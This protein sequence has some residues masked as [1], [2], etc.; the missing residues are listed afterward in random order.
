MDRALSRLALE[1]GGPRDLTAIR[2]GLE[3]ALLI[4]AA[5][6]ADAP[7][8]MQQ[9]ITD[10]GGHDELLD[11]LD[12]A[13][14]AEPPLLTRDGGFIAP[15]YHDELDEARTLRDEGRGV[16]ASMQAEYAEITG[17]SSLKVKHNNVLGYFI[18]C[19]ATHADKML[20]APLNETFIHRQT[21]ANAVR[22]TTVDLSEL[23]TRIL[24]A[25]GRALEIEK[26]LFETLRTAVLDNADRIAQSARALSEIDLTCAF[27]DLARDLNWCAPHIDDSRAFDIVGGRHPVVERALQK[28]GG[29]PF[30]ANDCN[31]SAQDDAAIWLLTGPNMAGKSTFLRQ[32]ALIALLAQAGSFVPATSVHIG[33]VS[34]LFSRVGAADD[35]AR[36]RSTFMVEM[37]ETAAILN[38]ADD[39]ALVILDE[40]G[41]GTA[42]YD[43]LSIAWATLEHLHD[44]NRSRAL[45]A[46]HY[47][48]MTTLADTLAGVQ[49]ATVAVKEWRGN[50]IFL[51]EVHKGAADRSYGVQVARLAGLP[52]AVVNRARV[53]LDALEER[54]RTQNGGSPLLTDLPLFAAAPPP[55]AAPATPE[56]SPALDMLDDIQPDDLT[57]RQALQVLY[58]LKKASQT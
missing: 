15:G 54:G 36:G 42:T 39:R 45:F 25:G 17:I 49:N 44:V 6:P 43:G 21:T 26:A 14:V 8:L 55:P 35:L 10:L 38:Q 2:N 41:R 47:H 22:F 29:T 9:A 3:Q 28:Q 52:D 13:L 31:L 32:N 57:P 56:P 19:T 12:N 30:V 4:A 27:A 53:V 33:L 11:L 7:D 23:E 34:Q 16:I 37:V 40:I 24:N 20:S 58:D 5:M 51:H 48:E 1:Q 18:E 50:V 46:T